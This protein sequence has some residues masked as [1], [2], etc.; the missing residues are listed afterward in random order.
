MT[1]TIRTLA[2]QPMVA[3]GGATSCR[4]DLSASLNPL[5]P[6]PAALAAALGS[7]LG[8]YPEADAGSLVKA[9]AARHRIGA[10]MVVPVPG[11]AA[12]IWLS[13]IDLVARGDACALLAP[14]FGEH[15][16]CLRMV[17]AEVRTV[18]DWPP[19]RWPPE[20]L[21]E[22]LADSPKLCLLANPSTPAGRALPAATLRRLCAAHPGTL[23]LVDEAFASFTPPGTSLLDEGA[24]PGNSLVV[25][26]LTKELG[27]PGLRMGYLVTSAER[28]AQL[29][30]LLPAWPLSAP[31]IAAAVAGMAEPDHVAR[32]AE[33]AR[34]TLA[35]VRLALEAAG[36]VTFPSDA[37][38]LTARADGLLERLRR[39]GVAGR[40]CASFGLAG[41]VRIAAPA[42]ADVAR[43]V[44][45]VGG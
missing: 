17:G 16:R 26:S 5:G 4:I 38:Y 32:G 20:G 9:V 40:D 43:V 24:P 44:E 29:R 28:A 1:M 33:V 41:H 31:A 34:S 25:R 37:N 12:G 11:A 7:P 30:G 13:L 18:W 8:S 27:L 36:A 42:P 6:H 21:E 14:S 39:A 10:A 2:G 23:F 19:Q 45:A 3:H 15:E 35:A 22:A